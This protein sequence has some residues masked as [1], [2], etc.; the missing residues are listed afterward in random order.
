MWLY[1]FLGTRAR[2]RPSMAGGPGNWP[3]MATLKGV[4]AHPPA[5][6][7]AI[8][9]RDCPHSLL[10]HHYSPAA[11]MTCINMTESR[12]FLPCGKFDRTQK[13][14]LS[15][16]LSNRRPNHAITRTSSGATNG[17]QQHPKAV[18]CPAP[19]AA[20]LCPISK[21]ARRPFVPSAVLKIA[22]ATDTHAE[23]ARDTSR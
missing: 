12:S 9:G 17:R 4:Y 19:S 23:E 15:C 16:S 5:R 18:R 21:A 10:K 22:A 3:S 14:T 11:S 6:T 2:S 1:Q 8:H 13:E 7:P 20:R